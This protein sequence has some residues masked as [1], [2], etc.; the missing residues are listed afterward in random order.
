[1]APGGYRDDETALLQA[2]SDQA[3][4]AV[5]NARLLREIEERNAELSESLELQTAT[6]EALRLIS[7]HPGDLRTVLD[8]IVSKAADLCDSP[9]GSVLLKDGPVLRISAAKMGVGADM[10]VGMEFP[11]DDGNVNTHA[12][13]SNTALAF[14][15]L[16]VIAPE[17]AETFPNS[18]SYAT[19]ALFSEA[20]WIGNIN[21]LRPEVRPFDDAELTVLQAFAD[22]ASLA[23]SNARLFNEL[24]AALE[25]QTAMT[26]VL[27]AVSTARLDLQPVFDRIAVHAHRL[28][29]EG[30]SVV[31]IVDGDETVI[32]GTDGYGT[33]WIA[34]ASVR[35]RID[36]NSTT[37]FVIDSGE[38]LHIRHSSEVTERFPGSRLI[39]TGLESWLILP[40][41]RDGDVIGA[42]GVARPEPGGY[43]DAEIAL[44]RAFTDQAAIAV[45]NARLLREI[46]ARNHEL[47]ESLELQTASSEVLQLISANPGDLTVVLE[48]V[49]SRAAT[50]CDAETGLI[51]L[52]QDGVWRCEAEVSA[53]VSFIGDEG[54]GWGSL[55]AGD[56]GALRRTP[57]FID[58]IRPVMAGLPLEGKTIE[59]GVRSMVAIPLVEHGDVIGLINVG[60]R[61]I[62][63]FDEKQA[64]IL[65]AFA[66]Q[67][68]IAVANAKLFNDLDAAL[69]RQTAMTDVLEAVS[70]SRS[71]L[72]PVFDRI[73]EHAQRLCKDV[74]AYVTLPDADVSVVAAAGA[75]I[76]G[77]DTFQNRSVPLDMNS[78]TGAVHATGEAIHIRDMHELAADRFPNTRARQMGARSLLVLPMGRHGEVIGS[79]GFMRSEPGGF[80]DNEMSLLKAFTDQA[81]IAVANARLLRE[82]EERNHELSESLELQTVTS[83]IL[84][85]IS[86][87]PGDLTTVLQGI[88]E[89]AA[90]L[91]DAQY[92]SV[93]LR[94]GDVLRIEAEASSADGARRMVGREFVAER[95]INRRARDARRPVFLDDFQEVRDTVGVQVA[96]EAPE[97]HSFASV[98]L[99]LDD[100]W[101][102]N[103]NVTRD[104][105]RPFDPKISPILQAFA[106][107]AAIAVA[108]AKL[109]NDLDAALERQTAMTEVLDAVSQARLDLQ[110]VFDKVAEHADRLCQ[111]TG[112]MVLVRE[113]DDLLLSASPGRSPIDARPR[114]R[115]TSSDRR[116]VGDGR[117][118]PARRSDP[119]P[120]LGRRVRRSVRDVTGTAPHPSQRPRRAHDARRGRHRSGGVHPPRS[121]RLHRRRDRPPRDVRR[122]G[123]HR[124]RQRPPAPRDRGTQS[125]PVGVAGAADRDLGNPAADQRQPGQ[126]RR[127]VRRNHRPVDPIVRRGWWSRPRT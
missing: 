124:R 54:A 126:P 109:F 125:R 127:G 78:T 85:L 123:R 82:I 115:S 65:Q 71:E 40:M 42:I 20:E 66:D 105:V 38:P 44:L 8:A 51:W 24:D 90:A 118:S 33:D 39:D 35:R 110:P 120:R 106:D 67:A 50:L 92:G 31:Q 79:I 119:R 19:V 16:H 48:G 97:L 64:N 49:I 102:G 55:L 57:T 27:E 28:A 95:T 75:N 5:D 103:L 21:I 63:P 81:A 1:V 104:E 96:R 29:H 91:C 101:I 77:G 76:P 43:D 73:V 34:D 17:L 112:A 108:N 15:D 107:Q 14:D 122:P 99:V 2:F 88:A 58:D 6:S 83:D 7:T 23:V 9:F 26:D 56:D 36:R 59:S 117:R 61:E 47:S 32:V 93:L 86:A 69:E 46:E 114:G 30:F 37:G 84:R 116:D 18:R 60:R 25:R 68:A 74:F 94:H 98:A 89:R 12:A 70:T 87:N 11:A 41:K 45:D 100:E 13:T 3:A 4:I 111:G 80:A 52:E 62:R 113:G 10:A 53:A 72:Q 22:Q 121:R